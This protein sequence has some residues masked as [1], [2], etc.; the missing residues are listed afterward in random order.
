M[1]YSAFDGLD[2]PDVGVAD[3]KVTD[4]L[5]LN[6]ILLHCEGDR[7][8]LGLIKSGIGSRVKGDLLISNC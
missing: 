4:K 6:T 2:G 1:A 8:S 7:V 3:D 5:V